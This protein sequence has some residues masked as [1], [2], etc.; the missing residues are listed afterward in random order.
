MMVLFKEAL[1]PHGLHKGS[2]FLGIQ[3]PKIHWKVH[4]QVGGRWCYTKRPRTGIPG[5]TPT[6]MFVQVETVHALRQLS[7]ATR[8]I[9][10][11]AQM[12]LHTAIIQTDI[13]AGFL[14]LISESP[15]GG[16]S[17]RMG[18]LFIRSEKDTLQ[19][20]KAA[21]SEEKTS[22]LT[23]DDESCVADGKHVT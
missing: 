12:L 3:G 5:T 23:I 17:A 4:T 1:V 7:G 21:T 15:I 8:R 10:N 2:L 11:L 16:M 20:A 18:R 13:P 14:K 6:V 22:W 9:I 19:G